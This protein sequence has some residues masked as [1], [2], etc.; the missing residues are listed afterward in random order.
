M[1]RPVLFFFWGGAFVILNL[2]SP[3]SALLA[4][5]RCFRELPLGRMGAAQAPLCLSLSFC[6]CFDFLGVV[7]RTTVRL[8][9]DHFLDHPLIFYLCT[10][11]GTSDSIFNNTTHTRGTNAHTLLANKHFTRAIGGRLNQ[12]YLF[13]CLLIMVWSNH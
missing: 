7:G 6:L 9:A 3:P 1:R 2:S 11:R 12:L 5:F 4:L 8:A 10:N 13:T